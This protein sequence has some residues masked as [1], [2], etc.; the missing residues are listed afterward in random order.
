MFL[1]Q[2]FQR[3]T[4]SS[5]IQRSNF[6]DILNVLKQPTQYILINTLPIHEQ[7]CLIPHTLS[8]HIEEKTINELLYKGTMKLYSIIVYG[9]NGNDTTAEDKYIQLKQLGFTN[10]YVYTGGLFEW[11]LLQD[12]YGA[13][14][15]PTTKKILDF[16]KYKPVSSIET[17]SNS[18]STIPRL[19]W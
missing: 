15:F 13:E 1:N 18:S 9:K 8:C 17:A 3:T 11:C 6:E 5:S 12:I 2:L 16:L 14:N 7:E 19:L 4:A 10:V